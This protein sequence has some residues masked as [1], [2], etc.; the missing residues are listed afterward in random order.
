VDG[1]EQAATL[2]DAVRD[3]DVVILVTSWPEF[4][5]VPA[6]LAGRETLVVDGRRMWSPDAFRNYRAPGR[7]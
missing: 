6:L 3:A 2:A 1:V 7:S 5:E 4:A